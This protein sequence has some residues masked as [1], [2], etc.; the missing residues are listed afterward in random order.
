[1][2]TAD[3]TLASALREKYVLAQEHK[4][5]TEML[6]ALTGLRQHWESVAASMLKAEHD[7]GPYTLPHDLPLNLEV[8]ITYWSS[9]ALFTRPDELT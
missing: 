9:R 6:G 8:A 5:A 3:A 4:H 7:R 1:M 2:K